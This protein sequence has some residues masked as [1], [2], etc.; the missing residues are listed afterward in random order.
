MDKKDLTY[1]DRLG[2]WIPRKKEN[3]IVQNPHKSG[4]N[5]NVDKII[6]AKESK[7]YKQKNQKKYKMKI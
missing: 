4:K 5:E 7:K 3:L 1:N 6:E 2:E